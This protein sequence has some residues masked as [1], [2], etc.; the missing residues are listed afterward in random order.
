MKQPSKGI[1]AFVC[2]AFQAP[3]LVPAVWVG[4]RC[5]WGGQVATPGSSLLQGGLGYGM[6]G[7]TI[8]GTEGLGA[9]NRVIPQ[10]VLK[11]VSL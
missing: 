3:G 2:S 6:A 7:T 9:F 11:K 1:K 10:Y 4:G 5:G 8:T